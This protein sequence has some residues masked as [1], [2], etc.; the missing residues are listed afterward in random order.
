MRVLSSD[1]DIRLV[2]LTVLGWLSCQFL[3]VPDSGE[4]TLQFLLWDGDLFR[5]G[6][7]PVVVHD[8][9]AGTDQDLP[10]LHLTQFVLQPGQSVRQLPV[11][12]A[13]VLDLQLPVRQGLQ[14]GN[15]QRRQSF[16]GLQVN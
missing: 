9:L 4:S 15:T 1:S 12:G 2:L 8:D 3:S 11:G 16:T 13:L 7:G 5:V 10:A 6:A 14:Q